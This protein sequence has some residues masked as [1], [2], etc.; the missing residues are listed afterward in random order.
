MKADVVFFYHVK[1]QLHWSIF[2]ALC[3]KD[4]SAIHIKGYV[5]VKALHL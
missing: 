3:H 4:L 2:V 1:Q 5:K